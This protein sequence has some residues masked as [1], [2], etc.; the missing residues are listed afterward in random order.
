[1]V[2][3]ANY[4][5]FIVVIDVNLRTKDA[6]RYRSIAL[7]P[8]G[9]K[10]THLGTTANGWFK[11]RYGD[12]L[13]YVHR[14]QVTSEKNY[15]SEDREIHDVPLKEPGNNQE[16]V[17]IIDQNLRTGDSSQYRSII[18]IPRG[19]SVNHLGTTKK[20]WF[21][22]DY[23]GIEGYLYRGDLTSSENYDKLSN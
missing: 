22:V 20:G 18:L 21:K 14:G 6:N 3:P 10:V 1:M 23:L 19:D 9:A 13:G 8:E 5:D 17:S 2:E 15:Y 4:Q 11:V 16:F 12:Q 7:M